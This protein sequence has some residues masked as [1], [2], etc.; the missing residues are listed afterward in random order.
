MEV[1]MT[2]F[3]IPKTVTRWMVA[4]SVL[5][6]VGCGDGGDTIAGPGVQAPTPRPSVGA[7]TPT[8]VAQTGHSDVSGDWRVVFTTNDPADCHSGNTRA[9]LA[10]TADHVSGTVYPVTNSCGFGGALE[11]TVTG[12]H[13]EGTLVHGS[14]GPGRV[15]GT[16]SPLEMHLTAADLIGPVVDGSGPLTPGGHLDLQR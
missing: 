13:F 1:V 6:P 15:S 4:L 3:L 2:Y 16:A 5:L 12:G 10:Q 9:R 14:F 11:G 8:P 7:P